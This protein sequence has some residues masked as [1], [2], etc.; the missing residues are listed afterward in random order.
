LCACNTDEQLRY[1]FFD[2]PSH[3]KFETA[4]TTSKECA[5]LPP[6]THI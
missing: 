3:A 4:R 6:L 5:L 1:L 2:H